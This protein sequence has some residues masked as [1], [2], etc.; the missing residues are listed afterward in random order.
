ME[1]VGRWWDNSHEIDVVGLSETDNL[2]V[3]GECKFW[4][5]PVGSNIL[6]QLEQKTTFVDWHKNSRKTIYMIFSINGFTED[7]Y[8]VAKS[9]EDV[10]LI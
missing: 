6:S 5:G 10:M 8:A 1:R 9:R 7:L 4:S 2:L 3:V